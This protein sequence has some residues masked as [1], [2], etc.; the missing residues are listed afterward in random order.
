MGRYVVYEA[1][2]VSSWE[3]EEVG[4]EWI[5][6]SSRKEWPGVKENLEAWKTFC[7]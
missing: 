1:G 6:D 2:K 7:C 5:F 4:V 3:K